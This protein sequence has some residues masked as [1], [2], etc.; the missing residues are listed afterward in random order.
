MSKHDSLLK[1]AEVYERLSLY[2]D[3]KSFL[4]AVAQAAQDPN[5]A[6]IQQALAILQQAGVD[7]AT[8]QPLGN[9]VLFNK[10]D[11]P[12]IQRAIQTATMTKMSPLTQQ[13]QISQ[14]KSLMSQM[15][16]PEGR[17][18]EQAMQG[19]PDVTFKNDRI[20]GYPPIDR[21]VQEAISRFVT[22]NGLG[23]PLDIDGVLGPKTKAA[24]ALI[25]KRMNQ[26]QATDAQA[27]AYVQQN[28]ATKPA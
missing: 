26:P 16:S 24:L 9:A 14:L 15:R 4:K 22:V 17:E 18:A 13:S 10:I 27:I 23:I 28:P 20:T 21:K 3:R 19:A 12:A 5:R 7:E 8:L 11:L 6:L 1:K 2:S 25:K